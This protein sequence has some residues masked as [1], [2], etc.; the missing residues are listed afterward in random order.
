MSFPFWVLSTF[1]LYWRDSLLIFCPHQCGDKPE[2]SSSWAA[3]GKISGEI[4]PMAVLVTD[5][6]QE[7]SQGM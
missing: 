3:A 1:G 4:V 2:W 6:V 5:R 7:G